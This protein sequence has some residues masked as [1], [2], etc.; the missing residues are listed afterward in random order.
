MRK[1]AR[2]GGTERAQ[3]VLD[4]LNTEIALD[5]LQE[6]KSE[7]WDKIALVV[8]SGATQTATP[9]EAIRNVKANKN[10]ATQEHVYRTASGNKLYNHGEK[11]VA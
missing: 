10:A 3:K 9:T 5:E 11:N 1:E 2:E 8:D 4:E 7:K 6:F